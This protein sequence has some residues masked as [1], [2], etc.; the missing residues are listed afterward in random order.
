M[1]P[2]HALDTAR[3]EFDRR[4][5]QVGPAD[6]ARSTSCE[7]WDVRDLARAIGADEA[8]D[9][10]LVEQVWAG[11][12]PMAPVIARSG[13]FGD[14]PSGLVGDDA[15]LQARLLDLSGRRP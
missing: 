2:L 10:G 7:G 9:V 13:V 4:L 3:A 5:G 8:L 1:E 11:L 6:W 15:A 14:G 12:I